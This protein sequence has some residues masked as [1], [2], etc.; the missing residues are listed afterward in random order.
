MGI[1]RLNYS[2]TLT[3]KTPGR[4]ELMSYTELSLKTKCNNG[5]EVLGL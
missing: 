4:K 5:K 1:F 2:R 3:T